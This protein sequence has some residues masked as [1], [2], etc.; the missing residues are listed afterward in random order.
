MRS[1]S[2]FAWRSLIVF[3][4]E[5]FL[6]VVYGFT[7][8]YA[9]AVFI[10]IIATFV[11]IVLGVIFAIESSSGRHRLYWQPVLMSVGAIAILFGALAGYYVWLTEGW[12]VKDCARFAG[13]LSLSFLPVMT[14]LVVGGIALFWLDL[15]SK[16]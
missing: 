3:I 10:I 6:M 7:H 2:S 14:F 16:E 5:V 9:D 12:L 1:L 15:F 8:S 4:V 11:M 13:L